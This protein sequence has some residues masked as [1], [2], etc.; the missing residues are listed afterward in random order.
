MSSCG[1]VNTPPALPEELLE[2]ALA[3]HWRFP[4]VA[5]DYLAVGFGSHHW[6][7]TAAGGERRFLTVDLLTKERFS[8]EPAAS[9]QSLDRA[10]RSALALYEGGLEFVVAP[11]RTEVG[12][13]VVPV[14]D[15]FAAALYPFVEGRTDPYGEFASDADRQAM[16]E[17]AERVHAA[18]GLA[19]GIAARDDL[20]LPARAKLEAALAALQHPWTGGPYSE[21]ARLALAEKADEVH[22][23]LELYDRLALRVRS[24]RTPWVLTHGEMHSRRCRSSSR[25]RS[26]SESRSPPGPPIR[27]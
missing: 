27:P 26:T 6:V 24:A 20:E 21:R 17:L 1:P 15:R 12:G 8:G 4:P 9:L 2:E 14:G 23:A 19:R 11:L 13:V 18:G 5:L 3:R 10:F 22:A 25:S 7:V 16:L